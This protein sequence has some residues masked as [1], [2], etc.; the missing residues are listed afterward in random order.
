MVA[1]PGVPPVTTPVVATIDA[2]AG[3][4]LLHV[5]PPKSLNV[6][7]PPVHTVAVPSIADGNGLTVNGTV[8]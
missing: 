1:V 4:L 7:M 2:V 8:V 6:V 3:A 5:P